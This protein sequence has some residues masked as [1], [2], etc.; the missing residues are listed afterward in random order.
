[1]AAMFLVSGAHHSIGKAATVAK[2]TRRG[3]LHFERAKTA[4]HFSGTT[5]QQKHISYRAQFSQG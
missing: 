3:A 2:D 1:M 4:I 5:D